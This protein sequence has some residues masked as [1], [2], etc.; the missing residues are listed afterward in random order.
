MTSREW[1]ELCSGGPVL[2]DGA[3]GTQLQERGLAVGEAPEAWNVTHPE[4]VQEVA[5]AYVEAGSQIVLTNSFGGNRITLGGHGLGDR[6]REINESAARLSREAAGTKAWVFGSIGPSGK[7]IMTGEV[8]EEQLRAA[9]EQQAQALQ[10]GGVD[11][12]VIETMAALDEACA[13]VR[14]AVST[15]LPVVA[16]M[17]YDS[18]PD[19]DR[20]MMGVSPAEAAEALGEA[21]AWA[22]GANCGQAPAGFV[23]VCKQYREASD[24]PLW[25]KPNAGAPEMVNETPVYRVA[26]EE[27]ARAAAPLWEAGATFVGGC[28][29]T[30]PAFIA[31][32]REVK[33]GYTGR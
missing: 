31:S 26:P 23:S 1:N 24:L 17:V 12:L 6:A 22:L 3:W 10:A 11:G 27:F 4:K 32:L 7:M 16:C 9:F 13:A 15:G 21:G 8:T 18:G 28:C 20:T 30:G 5:A 14:A 33:P 2:L 19:A 25:M 29:G